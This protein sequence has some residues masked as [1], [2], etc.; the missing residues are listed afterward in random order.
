MFLFLSILL[1]LLSSVQTQISPIQF[2][3]PFSMQNCPLGQRCESGVCQTV[4]S[5]SC[6]IL[7]CHNEH[8]DTFCED[9]QCVLR[10]GASCRFQQYPCS[11]GHE[12]RNGICQR[13]IDQP[14][15]LC[16]GRNFTCEDGRC[17]LR[18][19]A[20]CPHPF[21]SCS[22]GHDCRRG[23]CRISTSCPRCVGIDVICE[24]GQCVVK[25]GGY[26][27]LQLLPCSSGYECRNGRCT[28][29][30]PIC[31][32]PCFGPDIICED[33]RCVLRPG[34]RCPNS[35]YSC[36]SGHEC[37]R[38]RCTR[39][40]TECRFVDDC[41]PGYYCLY[42]KCVPYEPTRPTQFPPIPSETGCQNN[43]DCP[44]GQECLRI[45][46]QRQCVF[47]IS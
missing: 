25:P 18:P 5:T 2:C 13:N 32:Q 3:P 40:S 16:V 31:L 28:L 24:E 14:C 21:Y 7:P 47:V 8:P 15:P 29:I 41:S 9:G 19:G 42:G 46:S 38:G 37:R 4:V 22:S 45:G 34:A 10:P 43:G 39:S 30:D 23:R 35:F 11:S 26:C 44:R 20:R 33:G 27:A 36:S 12:C 6:P 1:L 17:V